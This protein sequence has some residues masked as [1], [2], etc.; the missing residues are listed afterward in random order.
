MIRGY[1]TRA[2]Q[3]VLALDGI[4]HLAEVISAYREEAWLTFGLTSFH[5]LIFFLGV[6][7]VGHDHKHHQE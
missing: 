5:T 7:L 1:L 6:Y 2:V 3:A 4:L